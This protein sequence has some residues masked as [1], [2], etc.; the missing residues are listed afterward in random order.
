MEA[1]R[2]SMTWRDDEAEVEELRTVHTF[3][4]EGLPTENI[5]SYS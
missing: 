3:R 5:W 4:P 1:A 2:E